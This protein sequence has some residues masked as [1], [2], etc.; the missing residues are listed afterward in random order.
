MG[1]GPL[2][3]MSTG[4]LLDRTFTLFRR[5]F[6]LFVGIMVLP[7][8]L[9]LP[10]KVVQVALPFLARSGGASPIIVVF[11][12]V[13]VLLYLTGG[14]VGILAQG[15]ALFAASEIQVGRATSIR[16]AYSKVRGK[17]WPLINTGMIYVLAVAGGFLLLL[18]PGVW[19]LLRG[20]LVFQIATLED[21]KGLAA[22]RRSIALTKGSAG[23]IFLVW[24]FVFI[25]AIVAAAIFQF[26]ATL[27]LPAPW[28]ATIGSM[29]AGIAGVLAGPV[30]AI[31]FTL[32]YFDQRVRKEAFDLQVMMA[33]LDQ[34]TPTPG[35]VPPPIPL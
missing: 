17:L 8:V 10:A 11:G 4:E 1:N 28:S 24:I 12:I 2:Q 15:A 13:A 19:L 16:Q 6:W 22:L 5:E 14:I 29:G 31:A 9:I 35:S 7:Q 26:P 23:H 27:L 34:P 33:A 18:I 25:I 21:V 32:V 20:A 3:P 30:A